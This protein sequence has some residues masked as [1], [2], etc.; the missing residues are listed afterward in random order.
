MVVLNAPTGGAALVSVSVML[1]VLA[2]L[3]VWVAVCPTGT[4]PNATGLGVMLRCAAPVTA[5][6]LMGTVTA[7][8]LLATASEPVWLPATVGV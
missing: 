8:A 2:M 6:P 1:P 7:P 4:D 5:V 3:N